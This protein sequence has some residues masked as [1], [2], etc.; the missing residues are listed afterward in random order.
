MS[1]HEGDA[2]KFDKGSHIIKHWMECHPTL[3]EIPKFHY[4]IRRSYKDCLSRQIGE[5]VAIMMTEDA[6]LN[7]KCEYLSNC[8]ARVKV[9]ETELERK[10]KEA[11]DEIKERERL[12]ALEN[13]RKEKEPAVK[14]M[15]RKEKETQSSHE[16]GDRKRQKTLQMQGGVVRLDTKIK[17]SK[18]AEKTPSGGE[19]LLAIEYFPTEPKEPKDEAPTNPKE[20]K[21]RL[22]RRKA[23]FE[24]RKFIEK[25]MRKG[26]SSSSD[27]VKPKLYGILTPG[28]R[29]REFK[30]ISSEG[31]LESP[32]K[33]F[34]LKLEHGGAGQMPKLKNVP[35]ITHNPVSA[36]V[37]ESDGHR[38]S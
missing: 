16:G 30:N 14:G 34:K 25:F 22:Q 2:R 28:K 1:E 13:F 32:A 38:L 10:K 29:T 21:A 31:K 23:E 6:I 17:C 5:A 27:S 35:K 12:I 15:K 24:K 18:A 4:K 26:D 36:D 19:V 11:M 20:V 9:D 33:K 37:D 3:R 8:I 7:D